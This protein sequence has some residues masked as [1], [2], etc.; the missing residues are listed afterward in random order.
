MKIRDLS[1][2]YENRKIFDQLNLDITRPAQMITGPSGSGKTTLLKI[3]CGYL[4]PIQAEFDILFKDKVLVLQEDSLFP[5]MTGWENITYVI[6][7]KKMTP[8]EIS[9][10]KLYQYIE[11]FVF[12]KSWK[13]SYGQR[14]CI[15]LFRSILFH[16]EL[17]CLDEPL[18]FID[19]E[20][21]KVFSEQIVSGS[22]A[23]QVIITTHEP[24]DFD[25]IKSDAIDLPRFFN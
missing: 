9:S 7:E 6:N 16:P 10:H 2:Q 17:L 25:T 23:G 3:L 19:P 22:A 18:N 5:W 11:D 15:E 1:F 12:Q 24:D 20:R 4:H 14:R 13:M 8:G 21:R